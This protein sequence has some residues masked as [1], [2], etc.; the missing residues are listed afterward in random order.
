[1]VIRSKEAIAVLFGVLLGISPSLAQRDTLWLPTLSR[2]AHTRRLTWAARE[3]SLAVR[4][5]VRRG[6]PRE[7]RIAQRGL[8]AP[9]MIDTVI[10]PVPKNWSQ[11]A[12][13]AAFDGDN[14]LV[15]WQD[16][17][18]SPEDPNI[19]CTRVSPSGTILDPAGGISVGPIPGI[20]AY[21]AVAFGNGTYLVVWVD[22][23]GSGFYIKGARLAP[24]GMVLD[25]PGFVITGT[26]SGRNPAAVALDG[27][28]FLV[29]WGD[30]RGASVDIYGARV[31]V[32][33]QVLDPNGIV[34][35]SV[36]GRQTLPAVAFGGGNY[37][38]VWQDS[39]NGNADI[40]GARVAP[41]GQV[42]DSSGIRVCG[43]NL[44]QEMPSVAFDGTNSLIVWDDWRN[45][46]SADIYAARLT[47]T[48]QVLDSFGIPVSTA[49][50]DQ[51][52]PA[53]TF[54]GSNYLA[55]WEDNRNPAT[56][57]Q[58]YGARVNP[59]GTVLEPDGIQV[60]DSTNARPM[61]MAAAGAGQSLAL[62]EA[63]D[64]FG[65]CHIEGTRVTTGGVVLDTSA[66]TISTD[67]DL[68]YTPAVAYDGTNY[69]V[70][71]AN[72]TLVYGRPNF[73]KF[74]IYGNRVSGSGEVLDSVGFRIAPVSIIGYSPFFPAIAFDGTNYLVVWQDGSIHAA[75]VTPDR[76]VLDSPPILVSAGPT[77]ISTEPAVAFD[78]NN[79]LVV[80]DD[81]RNGA[82]SD[83]YAARVSRDGQVLD[84]AGIVISSAA[85]NQRY[86]AVA[87]DGTDYLV[88]WQD[89]RTGDFD[90]YAARVTPSGDVLDTVGIPVSRAPDWQTEPAVAFDGTNYLVVWH[91]ARSSR[92]G[93]YCARVT[94]AGVVLDTG[95]VY[96][97]ASFVGLGSS[98]MSVVFDGVNY[99]ATWTRTGGRDGMVAGAV[100]GPPAVVLDT[101]V[102]AEG[103]FPNIALGNAGRKLVVWDCFTD[104][105]QGR[106]YGTYRTWGRM[107]PFGGV[108]ENCRQGPNQGAGVSV[109]PNPA[110][111]YFWVRSPEQIVSLRIFN[112][113]GR[114]VRLE[115]R[116]DRTEDRKL[117]VTT[118]NMP[119][120]VYFL[121]LGTGTRSVR[122]KLVVE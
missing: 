9:F 8:G 88:A 100:I 78:G 10:R 15:V 2:E 3:S 30:G 39:R 116:V 99:F 6:E 121:E 34:I 1:M 113:G 41:S 26:P 18:D 33:G 98:G 108:T 42:L 70:V 62:W 72:Q 28:N 104:I 114:L 66:V 105:V 80:W 85:L 58:V 82:Y 24:S 68:Q 40:Y 94:T 5:A 21:P 29:V 69:L 77:D 31:S 101:L 32:D 45:Q 57:P 109:L 20:Q 11:F 64:I 79:Y 67:A 14:Y 50:G 81:W 65:A 43:A 61:A 63:M 52:E 93:A 106:P 13:A 91:D 119:K 95:G 48:G 49:T 27:V 107:S 19:C 56:A 89:R 55:V 84:T 35:S 87:F 75:R 97:A 112:A 37:T 25:S 22:S 53:V 103:L 102:I 92:P 36:A 17:L 96:I 7:G 73:Q 120:G 115:R 118:E 46:S 86:A 59:S 111:S 76:A 71:W 54:D 16:Y 12:P 51:L 4:S 90:I 44:D 23:S 110:H 122:T 117:K 83:L 47:P 74:T 38:V 60:S